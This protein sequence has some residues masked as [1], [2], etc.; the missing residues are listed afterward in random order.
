MALLISHGDSIK[1]KQLDIHDPIEF[2]QIF[3]IV[4]ETH[5]LIIR[6]YQGSIKGKWLLKS[7]NNHPSHIPQFQDFE[8]SINKVVELYKVNQV[9]KTFC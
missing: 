3:L 7:E 9:L 8:F 1:V 6:I 2:G 5:S 4:T